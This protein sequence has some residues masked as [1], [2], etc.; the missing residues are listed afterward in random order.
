L[1]EG[2]G[3]SQA[4][5]CEGVLSWRRSTRK[6]STR[7]GRPLMR[8]RSAVALHS[9]REGV[10][11]SFEWFIKFFRLICLCA[12]IIGPDLG[13]IIHTHTVSLF[14]IFHLCLCTAIWGWR[15]AFL[16]E[17]SEKVASAHDQLG[18]LH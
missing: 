8:R 3:R 11:L 15:P 2:R 18:G 12:A 10:N 4:N 1:R 14:Y 6:R 5:I 17:M 9:K 7:W 16:K 13:S